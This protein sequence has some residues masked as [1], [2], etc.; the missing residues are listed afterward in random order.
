MNWN[1]T[2]LSQTCKF[3][4]LEILGIGVFAAGL[5]LKSVLII[6]KYNFVVKY[7]FRIYIVIYFVWVM[8]TG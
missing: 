2:K 5:S 4:I 7:I 8:A 3:K 6:L 1:V